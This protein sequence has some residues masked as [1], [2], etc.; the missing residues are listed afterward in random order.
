MQNKDG[1]VLFQNFIYLS[2]MQIA[3]FVFPLLTLPY[4]SRIVGTEGFGKVAFAS[5][6][7][8]WVQTISDWGFNYTGTRS[9]AVVR[10]NID[11][12]SQIF[13][14][15]FWSRIILSVFSL[16]SLLLLILFVPEFR[17]NKN[18]ILITFLM[19]PGNILVSEW[20]FQALERM[21]Y[22]TLFNLL[23][24]FIFM[25]CVFLFV[26]EKE[27]YVLQPLF[28]SLG[29][30]TSGCISM[31]FILVRWKVKLRKPAFNEI[32]VTIKNSTDVFI[33]NL[34]P[35]FYNSMSTILLGFYSSSSSVGV[36]S[37]GK[38]FV[39]V[40]NSMVSII[41]RVFYPYLA[42][43]SDKHSTFAKINII[44]SLFVTL[45]LFALAPLII[46]IFY[47]DE[48]VGSISVL[49]ITSIALFFITLNTVYGTNF[50][51][52]H[53]CDKLLRNITITSSVFGLLL[54]FPL[55]IYFDY[56]GA[57]LTFLIS[58]ILLG[59]MPMYYA[60]RIKNS[61]VK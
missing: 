45:F 61:V 27:D 14:N 55:I 31:Y 4:L 58:S 33:N 23:A 53:N 9:L 38:N 18:V 37:S 12:V 40:S 22:I 60:F 10:E 44:V 47:T 46:H 3:G 13:S 35:N 26:R 30:L 5:A 25:I 24:K 29:F 32:F 7:I 36:Y 54:S 21:K 28:I 56:I 20:F 50:L 59:I 11:E 57:A 2:L 48:F 52:L 41:S 6:V 17:E 16:L 8:I 15:I 43:R 39:S 1:K 51:L 34:M 49:R 42:R 19:V